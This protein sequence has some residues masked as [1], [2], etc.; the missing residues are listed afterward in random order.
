MAASVIRST[1]GRI[2]AMARAAA[3]TSGSVG[4]DSEADLV[5]ALAN[6]Y[7]TATIPARGFIQIGIAKARSSSA[8]GEIT[9]DTPIAK[10]V[11]AL[12]NAYRDAIAEAA[13][14]AGSWAVPHSPSSRDDDGQLLGGRLADLQ[15]EVTTSG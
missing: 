8:V 15:A 1:I 7:G 13:N 3:S 9:L 2:T 14:T 4:Y 11:E 10:I 5:A 12:A 6:S